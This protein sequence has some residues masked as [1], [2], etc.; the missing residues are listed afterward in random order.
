M[1]L[2]IK[3]EVSDI[4]SSFYSRSKVDFKLSSFKECD[5]F[6]LSHK[7]LI[8]DRARSRQFGNERI[9]GLICH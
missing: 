8:Q 1:H 9:I 3:W 4:G 2:K 6:C 7:Q 5:L